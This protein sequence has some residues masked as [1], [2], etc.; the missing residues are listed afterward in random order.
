MLNSNLWSH[1]NGLEELKANKNALIK[2]R[3]NALKQIENATN[4]AM[5]L[6]IIVGAGHGLNYTNI[7]DL[8]KIDGICDFQIGQSI[9]ARSIFVGLKQAVKDMRDIIRNVK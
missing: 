1:K 3:A 5:D 6:G 4:R 2:K 8:L 7:H 9:I